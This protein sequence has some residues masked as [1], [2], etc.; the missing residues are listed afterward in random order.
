MKI[1]VPWVSCNIPV[2]SLPRQVIG[3]VPCL[4]LSPQVFVVFVA[5]QSLQ[6]R[7]TS[8]RSP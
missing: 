5:S 2:G 4:I 8:R 3:L 6:R 7:Q 1:C